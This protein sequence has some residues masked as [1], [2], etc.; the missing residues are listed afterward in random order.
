MPLVTDLSLST[1]QRIYSLSFEVVC[2]VCLC[3]PVFGGCFFFFF[4]CVC[5]CVLTAA[6]P[7]TVTHLQ[8]DE[9]G[10]FTEEDWYQKG[11]VNTF[12]GYQ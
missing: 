9:R 7:L 2:V 1:D 3:H 11:M 8:H 4:V 6:Q 12:S 10:H 5:V